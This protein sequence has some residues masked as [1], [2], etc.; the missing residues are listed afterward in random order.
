MPEARNTSAKNFH[1]ELQLTKRDYLR[2]Y[3]RQFWRG[4]GLLVFLASC[5]SLF[6]IWRTPAFRHELQAGMPS[7]IRTAAAAYCVAAFFLA[8]TVELLARS[9]SSL[10]VRKTPL[11]LAPQSLTFSSEGMQSQTRSI[12]GLVRWKT[13]VKAIAT[14][15]A[16]QL[17]SSPTQYVLL[18]FDRFRSPEELRG[19]RQM[20]KQQLGNRAR[21]S[22]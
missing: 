21:F 2:A 12:S 18:P 9:Y 20:L 3:R 16:F 6:P 15:R 11:A 22:A 19:F 14:S 10:V 7:A 8:F 4:L 13:F 5:L 17:Y 1:L